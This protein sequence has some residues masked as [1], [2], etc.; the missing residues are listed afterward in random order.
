MALGKKKDKL[1]DIEDVIT[2]V[3]EEG[4]DPEELVE[5]HEEAA[6]EPSEEDSPP[7]SDPLAES[8]GAE[9]EEANAA[10]AEAEASD[11]FDRDFHQSEAGG[12][13]RRVAHEDGERAPDPRLV[14]EV[15]SDGGV[16]RN[17]ASLTAANDA[18]FN[19]S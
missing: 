16:V 10:E 15:V 3:L 18:H 9:L 13:K 7:V 5:E 11:S 14:S 1:V 12:S 4:Q 6:G 17:P 8:R 19:I 2:E